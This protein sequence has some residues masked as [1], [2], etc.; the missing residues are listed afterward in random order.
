MEWTEKAPLPAECRH[1]RAKDCYN[2]DTAGKRWQLSRKEELLLRRTGILQA[3]ARLER[4]L[5]HIDKALE[6]L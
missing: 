2:C 5:A 3:I 4:Q 6:E 1:C